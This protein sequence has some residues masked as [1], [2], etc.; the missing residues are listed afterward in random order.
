MSFLPGSL[1]PALLRSY[2]RKVVS[3][4]RRS[5]SFEIGICFIGSLRV[6]YFV[7]TKKPITQSITNRREHS[8]RFKEMFY[9]IG[10]VIQ[11]RVLLRT[12]PANRTKGIVEQFGTF[13]STE[14]VSGRPD[15]S[16]YG[17]T[18]LFSCYVAAYRCVIII[19]IMGYAV[20]VVNPLIIFGSSKGIFQ[21]LQ[22]TSLYLLGHLTEK[23]QRCKNPCQR[24]T[25]YISKNSVQLG[26][27]FQNHTSDQI[28]QKLKANFDT[29]C[30]EVKKS[31]LC[32]LRR[33][34][35]VTSTQVVYKL[36]LHECKRQD[37]NFFTVSAFE[38]NS[39]G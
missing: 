14:S 38:N 1:T 31:L 33:S 18:F 4:F 20:K 9:V 19:Q 24:G 2:R 34:C 36:N 13:R 10:F 29:S 5:F 26:Q 8:S 3:P 28:G 17:R 37:T 7:K 12:T 39:I 22:K 25:N 21:R 16:Q 23:N 30:V 32:N 27:N 6:R 11:S 15:I 35:S